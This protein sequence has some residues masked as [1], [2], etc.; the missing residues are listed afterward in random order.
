MLVSAPEARSAEGAE[1]G[2]SRPVSEA[3]DL[4]KTVTYFYGQFLSNTN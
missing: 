3:A 4:F 2:V 1:G